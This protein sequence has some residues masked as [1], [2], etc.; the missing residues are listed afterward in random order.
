MPSRSRP[1]SRRRGRRSLS[2]Y[3]AEQGNVSI[4]PEASNLA[5]VP[6]PKPGVNRVR[7]PLAILLFVSLSATIAHAQSGVRPLPSPTPRNE[8]QEPL[9]VFTEEVR[10]P[11]AATDTYG[12]Y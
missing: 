11:V 3:L 4:R 8:D 2:F 1:S 9:R 7:F 12:H 10:L 6:K 5:L